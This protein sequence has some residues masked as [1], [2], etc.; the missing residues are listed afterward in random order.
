M[1]KLKF[2]F[3]LIFLIILSSVLLVGGT[4]PYFL[5]YIFSLTFLIPLIHSL[6]SLVAL[7]GSV[8]IPTQSLYSGERVSIEYKVKNNSIFPI[9]YLE[10]KNDISKQLTGI[11]APSV[12]LSLGKKQ[13]FSH[14]ETVLLKRRG[15]Y[16]LGEIEITIRDVFGFF[17]FKKKIS[18]S[19]SLLV[20]PETIN[21]ST[22]KISA[23][24]Q[25]G[26][27]IVHNSFF[28]DKSR[29]TSIREYREGDSIKSIHWKLS[30]KKDF[31]IIKNYENRGDTHAIIFIDNE[32][33]L[34]KDDVDRRIEDKAVDTALSITNY[35]LNQNI[36]INLE[37]QNA[38]EYIS[39]KGKQNS[40][41]KPFLEVLARFK[42]NGALQFNSIIMPKVEMLRRSSTV[43]IIT[44]NLDK[45]MGAHG[46]YLKMKN[47]NPLFVVIT[48]MENK[49]GYI[50]PLIQ[51]RIKQEGIPMYII[52]Y[53]TNIK[54]TLEVYHG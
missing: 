40:D 42:G 36:E 26:E 31:P 20:Y 39:I 15:Y 53:R 33:K 8:I 48:D 6:I 13:S 46:I 51:K 3:S 12:I 19:T 24:H 7:K 50:D 25:L 10:I 47:L 4:M 23:S 27:L 21:L 22:F 18:S 2:G 35:C 37:T 29:V 30:A 45:S 49:T 11:D 38:T 16:Q 14:K 5:F 44:P 9:A 32:A 34:F 52:D 54:E 1:T 43:V 17:T 41:L 28:E